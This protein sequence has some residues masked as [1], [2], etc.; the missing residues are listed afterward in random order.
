M[1]DPQILSRLDALL[2]P[3]CLSASSSTPARCFRVANESLSCALSCSHFM[4]ISSHSCFTAQ[5]Y[6]NDQSR[7]PTPARRSGSEPFDSRAARAQELTS[8]SG[9]QSQL[10]LTRLVINNKPLAN[11]QV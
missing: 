6:A 1:N 5:T 11:L 8:L 10:S 4:C 3:A 2:M 7:R 9:T